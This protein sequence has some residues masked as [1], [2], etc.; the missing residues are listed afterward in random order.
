MKLWLLLIMFLLGLGL[1]LSVPSFAPQYLD[2]YFPKMMKPSSQEVKGVVVKKQ[3]KP[4][5]LLLTISSKEGAILATFKK[6]I[7]EIT[8]LVDEGDSITLAVNNYAPFVTDPRILRVNKP[9]AG[10]PIPAT[11]NHLGAPAPTIEEPDTIL[12]ESLT[13]TQESP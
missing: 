4:N 7:A 1:G 13:T 3:T 8:L 12:E 5:R 10:S 2:L 11:P 9:E 6:K